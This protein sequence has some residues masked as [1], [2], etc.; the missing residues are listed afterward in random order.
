MVR[1]SEKK[2]RRERR[3]ETKRGGGGWKVEKNTSK[4]KRG[5][6]T[7][8]ARYGRHDMVAR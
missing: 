5:K 7:K 3:E 4:V 8:K 1:D 2:N 6:K